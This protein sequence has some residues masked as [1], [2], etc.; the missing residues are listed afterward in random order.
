MNNKSKMLDR[1]RN[2]VNWKVKSEKF[3]KYK[4]T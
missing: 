1:N 3:L 2:I 4:I